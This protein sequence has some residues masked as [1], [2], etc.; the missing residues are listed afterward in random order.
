MSCVEFSVGIPSTRLSLI[1]TLFPLSDKLTI[2]PPYITLPSTTETL[3]LACF[4]NMQKPLS[5]P[6]TSSPSELSSMNYGI[7]TFSISLKPLSCSP[8]PT[9]FFPL[10]SFYDFSVSLLL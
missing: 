10:L 4:P 7:L 3:S 6:L 1:C 8:I 5:L 9:D 2:C